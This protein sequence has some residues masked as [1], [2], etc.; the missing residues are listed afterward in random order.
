VT[1]ENN[2]QQLAYQYVDSQGNKHAGA[3]IDSLQYVTS[4]SVM[5]RTAQWEGYAAT[6]STLVDKL[7]LV[8]MAGQMP[9]AMRTTL[10]N[11]AAA[12]PAA[13]PAARVIETAELVVDS[14][15]FAIQR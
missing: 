10:I 8:L 14:P 2:L 15:Q 3:D 12:I 7:N 6:P 5:L 13:N 1:L 9:S 4:S 11:Y